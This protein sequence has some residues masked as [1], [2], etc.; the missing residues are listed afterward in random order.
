MR[1][2]EANNL[3]SNAARAPT[4]ECR[5]GKWST[6]PILFVSCFRVVNAWIATRWSQ[7]SL[8]YSLHRLTCPSV[9]LY[10]HQ[11]VARQSSSVLVQVSSQYPNNGLDLGTICE[12]VL[13]TLFTTIWRLVQFD[14]LVDWTH[15]WIKRAPGGTAQFSP[16]CSQESIAPDR[17]FCIVVD[18]SN[19]L[20]VEGAVFLVIKKRLSS[21][22]WW[23]TVSMYSLIFFLV[24]IVKSYVDFVLGSAS[25]HFSKLVI[26]EGTI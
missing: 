1:S 17:F 8:S 15:K 3:E 19:N 18:V 5:V 11:V 13:V 16:D 22:Q 6:R 20:I 25:N 23:K 10:E 24:V 12:Q 26:L 14:K 2:E 4:L 7:I 21:F 9:Y